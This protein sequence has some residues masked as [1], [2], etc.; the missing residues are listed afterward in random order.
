MQDSPES[1][2]QNPEADDRYARH[3]LIEGWDQERLAAARVLVAGAGAIG[4]E[5]IKLLALLG[6]GNILIVDFDHI[7]ISNL[8]RSMLFRDADIGKSKALVAAER[9]RE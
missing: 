3:R 6:V 9:A 5:V 7:E 2:I 4:N 1:R 8:T